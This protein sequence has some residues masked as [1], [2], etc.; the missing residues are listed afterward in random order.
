MLTTSSASGIR[1]AV[2]KR[3]VPS[4]SWRI[5]LLDFNS[6][7]G[8][9]A[10]AI[11]DPASAFHKTYVTSYTSIE[12][13]FTAAFNFDKRINFV[14][15]NAGIPEASD[16][17][18][19]SSDSNILPPQPNTACVDVCLGGVINTSHLAAHFF[20][21]TPKSD[22]S[23]RALV[24][25]ASC[26]SLYP[27]GFLPIYTGAKHGV[28]GFMRAISAK[29]YATDGIRVNALLPGTVRTNMMGDVQGG[30]FPKEYFTPRGDVRG[31]RD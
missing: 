14:F 30:K 31:C 3:L 28:L 15:A 29:Y 12:N 21:Q 2:A 20:Q 16:F 6:K 27:S 13:S 26:V 1:L 22:N 10:A 8:N 17:Y 7:T 23:P 5:H 9:A 4:G 11:L 19:S 25:T 18:T 24:I